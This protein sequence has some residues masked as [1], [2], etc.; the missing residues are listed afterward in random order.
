METMMN[1]EYIVFDGV[2]TIDYI[3]MSDYDKDYFKKDREVIVEE[4]FYP[5][6]IVN[7]KTGF[8]K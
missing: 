3:P 1:P 8:F 7:N 4:P 6:A 5:L 2:R